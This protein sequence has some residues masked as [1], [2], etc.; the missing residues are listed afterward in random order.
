MCKTRSDLWSETQI[1]SATQVPSQLL[2]NFGGF[3]VKLQFHVRHDNLHQVGK[4]TASPKV[5]GTFEHGDVP[6]I[7]AKP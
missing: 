3:K 4:E 1:S 5:L 2:Q 7:L 6:Q